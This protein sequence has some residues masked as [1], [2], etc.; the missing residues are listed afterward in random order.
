M[1]IKLKAL[2][3][4]LLAI[5][6]TSAFAVMNASAEVQGHF[7]SDEEHTI[8]TGVEEGTHHQHLVGDFGE[9]QIGCEV[10]HYHGTATSKTSTSLTITPTYEKCLTTGTATAVNVTTNGC[11]YTFTLTT[12]APTPEH[13]HLV[14][15]LLCPAGKAIEVHHPNCTITIQPQT[16]A[17]AG[18]VTTILDNGKHALTLNTAAKFNDQYHGGICIFLGTNHTGELKGSATVR[19]FNTEGKQVNITAT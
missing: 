4:G 1:S 12:T 7:V 19:G 18:T 11:T 16:V 6:A 5:L 14:A 15:H 2:G 10:A 9:G 17:S 3:L 8:I 13:P